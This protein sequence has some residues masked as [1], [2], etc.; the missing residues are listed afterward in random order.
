MAM[1]SLAHIYDNGAVGV[2]AD[3]VLARQWAERT[4]HH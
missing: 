4:D 1:A 2:P 3:P